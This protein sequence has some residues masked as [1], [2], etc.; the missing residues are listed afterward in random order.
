MTLGEAIEQQMRVMYALILRD[1]RTRYGRAF[2]GFVLM[3]VWPLTHALILMVG[4]YVA[5]KV[6]PIGTDVSVFV[7]TGALPYILCLYPARMMM[8]AIVVNQPLL[9][10]PIVKTFDIIIA[11]GILEIILAFWVVLLFC[12]ILFVAGVDFMP[13]H[14]EEAVMAILVTIYLGFSIGCL[15]AVFYKLTRAWIAVQLAVLGVMYV[16]S[17]AFFLPSAMPQWIRN[18]IWYN[19]LLHTVEWLRTSYYEGYGHGM[20]DPAYPIAFSTILLFIALAAERAVRGRLMEA[21]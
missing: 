15:G 20:L 7:A 17:G 14:P 21:Y 9:N 1:T 2:A 5:H 13:Q 12:L 16:T 10:F 3:I 6:A 18:I 11:R 19:P 4:Y 8:F